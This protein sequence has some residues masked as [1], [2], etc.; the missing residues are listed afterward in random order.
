MAENWL[1]QLELR[2]SLPVYES[3]IFSRSRLFPSCLTPQ[4]S[5]RANL[6]SRLLTVA[7][8]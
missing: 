5:Q 1:G 8:C 6:K 3:F 7:S 4:L 2:V